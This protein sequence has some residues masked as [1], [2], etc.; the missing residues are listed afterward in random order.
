LLMDERDGV[1]IARHRKTAR[2][3]RCRPA[4]YDS[5]SPGV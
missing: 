4:E 3:T 1:T 5:C 2:T